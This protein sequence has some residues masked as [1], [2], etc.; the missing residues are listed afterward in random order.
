[1]NWLEQLTKRLFVAASVTLLPAITVLI[2]IDT[3]LRYVF[4]SPI[5]WSQDAVAVALFVLFCICLPYSAWDQDI[6]VRLEIFH[7]HLPNGCKSL[8]KF[9]TACS[10]LLLG[11]IFAYRA[12]AV[13]LDSYSVGETMPSGAI[14]TWPIDAIAAICMITF[15][16]SSLGFLLKSGADRHSPD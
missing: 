10:A 15:S 1:M 11:I 3:I 14:F 9:L 8:V 6:H 2:T 13:T 4:S 16:I 12:V 5:A 7:A